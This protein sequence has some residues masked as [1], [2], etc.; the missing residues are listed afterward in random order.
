LIFIVQSI[1]A[2]V[3]L[4]L[5]KAIGISMSAFSL[6]GGALLASI[7]YSLMS[8][9]MHS[10][11]HNDIHHAANAVDDP[12]IIPITIPLCIGPGV[13]VTIIAYMAHHGGWTPDL[14]FNVECV[15]A[16]VSLLSGLVFMS[17]LYAPKLS[18]KTIYVIN[19]LMGLVICSM[20]A[21]LIINAIKVL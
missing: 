2:L 9:E 21:Q 6:A 3:G 1:V 5:L 14:Y 8:G 12:S 15:I 10:S 20:G 19:R 16:G 11:N 7:G 4:A 17:T 18:L 13:M